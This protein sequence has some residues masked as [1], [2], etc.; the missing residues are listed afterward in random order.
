[1]APKCYWKK[2]NNTFLTTYCNLSQTDWTPPLCVFVLLM[3][4][5]IRGSWRRWG[6]ACGRRSWCPTWVRWTLR[7]SMRSWRRATR[8]FWK[9]TGES[10]RGLRH[11]PDQTLRCCWPG[12]HPLSIQVVCPVCTK[13]TSP[14]TLAATKK[15]LSWCNKITVLIKE[16]YRLM[17]A[18]SG[19]SVEKTC[20]FA[21]WCWYSRGERCSW[22]VR[23]PVCSMCSITLCEINWCV[24][25]HRW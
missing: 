25:F 16:C 5:R 12:A 19:V 13:P 20:L 17:V 22:R 4:R 3:Y 1:M 10:L 11:R 14:Q 7:R 15:K 18:E 9:T 24:I 6:S 23:L 21:S 8:L 2:N